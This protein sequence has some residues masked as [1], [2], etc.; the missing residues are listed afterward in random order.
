MDSTRADCPVAATSSSFQHYATSVRNPGSRTRLLGRLTPS[1]L[2]KSTNLAGQVF[3]FD[4]AC[5]DFGTGGEL[6]S[7]LGLGASFFDGEGELELGAKGFGE[8][9]GGGTLRGEDVLSAGE[10][11]LGEG[12]REIAPGVYRSA[13]GTRQ[14]RMTPA[15]LGDSQPHVH[16]EYIRPDGRTENAHGHLK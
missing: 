15:D 5:A 3:G 13:D 7:A 11:W 1:R 12:Y 9:A 6:G 16:F 8:I 10:R 2:G 4:P 14:F